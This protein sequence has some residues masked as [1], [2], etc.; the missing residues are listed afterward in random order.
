M[1]VS[2]LDELRD[3]VNLLITGLDHLPGAN[4]LRFAV[5]TIDKRLTSLQTICMERKSSLATVINHLVE[6]ASLESHLYSWI[7]KCSNFL[8]STFSSEVPI[9][10]DLPAALGLDYLEQ[11]G[12]LWLFMLYSLSF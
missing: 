10:K 3:L 1:L 6:M 8:D 4:D 9:V 2:D 5:K 7:D 11:V 12:F